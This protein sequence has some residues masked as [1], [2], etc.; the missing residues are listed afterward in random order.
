MKAMSTDNRGTAES[1]EDVWIHSICDMCFSH[2]PIVVHRV[3]GVVVKIEGD[4]EGPFGNKR[5]C[6]KGFAGLMS[7]YDP[8]RL[9]KPLRRTN[10]K[11]GFDID[12]G[13]QEI[14]WD[15]ALDVIAEKL[16]KL[17]EDDPRKLQVSTAST[18]SMQDFVGTVWA[19]AF[20]TRNVRWSGYFCGNY[21]HSAMY[22]TN[23][24]FHSDFDIDNCNYLILQGNQAGFMVGLNSNLTAQKM[25]EAR[26]RGMKVVAVDPIL[27][28]AS[29]KADEWI[30]IRP[31]TDGAWMLGLTN[32][33][34]NE[35]RLYDTEFIKKKTNG[36]Y[37]VG[38]NGHY[39]MVGQK[40]LV[41]DAIDGVAKPF[42]AN[43][44]DHALDG[45]YLVHGVECRP[46]FYHFKEALKEYSP[47]KVEQI[48][49]IPSETVR[50][51]AQEFG[52]AACIGSTVVVEGREVPHRPVAV[53][54]YRGAGAHTHGVFAALAVQVLNL[55]VGNYY[56]VGGHRGTN[57]V[58]PEKSWVPKMSSEGMVVPQFLGGHGPDYYD[59]E[60]RPPSA[61]H[62]QELLPISSNQSAMVQHTVENPERFKM[63][64]KPEMLIVMR[65]N[66]LMTTANPK[67]TAR[68]FMEIP[69]VVYFATHM[70][71]QA[72]FADIVLPDV[73]YLESLQLFLD[74]WSMEVNQPA[75][76]FCW[77]IRQPIVS[78]PA[79]ARPWIDVLIEL[80]HK[81]GFADQVYR[82]V[83]VAYNL[84]DPHKL[85][86]NKR[87][88]MAEV[89]DRR[90]K[91]LFGLEMGLDWFKEH[92]VHMVKKSVE[93]LYP[94]AFLPHRFPV[95]YEN[96]LR[97][98]EEVESL[99]KEM[100][101]EWDT[102]D[103]KA[104][105]YWKPCEAFSQEPRED[106]YAVNYRVP[107]HALSYTIENPWLNE[108]GRFHPSAYKIL[109]NAEAARRRGI[110]D[111][112]VIRLESE[113]GSVSGTAKVTEGVHPEV[114]GIAGTFGSEAE[115]R[116]VAKGTGVHF[117]S[118][119]PIDLKRTDLISGGLD[120]C[121]RV[122]V[123][124][125]SK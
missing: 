61:T 84:K 4:P 97:A 32:V 118:L 98:G 44:R 102:S 6:A 26:L 53:N 3:N 24:T 70:D 79:Q 85:D 7:L 17:K 112:D 50:R 124:K 82:L 91:S 16:K 52:E 113:A 12:P 81:V 49:T 121:V 2:C 19:P 34:V 123:T 46:A 11:K 29:G 10:P 68:V 35:L 86:P 39:I 40:P 74:S 88:S 76:H 116:P 111:G 54:I 75:N 55:I 83:N 18:E 90:A 21:L 104:T 57:L 60:V 78:P 8:N 115:G 109:I 63:P 42:D 99:T 108:L 37:L 13:W 14:L 20:G 107:I 87:Y 71:E 56:A 30:P 66:Q 25:S 9:A 23:G 33:L 59:F 28:N 15:E 69:F 41:W 80:A 31:G 119:I 58:G 64:Y 100:G 51:I 89:Y 110:D 122:K 92:G 36:P 38:P 67:R 94:S 22:L 47:E 62:L 106:F 117:N 103:Y 27:T 96:V 101:I 93:E 43:V 120:S 77:R 125:V 45:V 105:P 72:Q 65:H 5:L 95:Y 114:V 73:H 1:K 48:T